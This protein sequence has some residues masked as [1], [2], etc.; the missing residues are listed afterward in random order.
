MFRRFGWL[1]RARSQYPRSQAAPTL[2]RVPGEP[3]DAEV[4]AAIAVKVI[5]ER[6]KGRW[7]ALSRAQRSSMPGEALY[8]ASKVQ[9][10]RAALAIENQYAREYALHQVADLC[11]TAGKLDDATVYRNLLPDAAEIA[12]QREAA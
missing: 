11:L 1:K 5:C 8:T 12:G 7:Q 2:V 9:A 10:L 3:E 6:F 4:Q